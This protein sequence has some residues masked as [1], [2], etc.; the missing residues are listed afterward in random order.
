MLPGQQT[1]MCGLS[2]RP[3]LHIEVILHHA[4]PD[5]SHPHKS[6]QVIVLVPN[7]VLREYVDCPTI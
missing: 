4:L 3:G 5:M 1:S 6:L 2:Q 7:S